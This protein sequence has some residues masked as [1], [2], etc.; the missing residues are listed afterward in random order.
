MDFAQIYDLIRPVLLEKCKDV[1]FMPRDVL[2]VLEERG[3]YGVDRNKR[4]RLLR[5]A[6]KELSEMSEEYEVMGKADNVQEFIERNVDTDNWD[7]VGASGWGEDGNL[8]FAVKLK[9]RVSDVDVRDLADRIKEYITAAPPM[10]NDATSK[11]P[12]KV[13]VQIEMPDLHFNKRFVNEDGGRK[14]DTYFGVFARMIHSA[15]KNVHASYGQDVGKDFT[16]L[17]F[18]DM[19]NSEAL[20]TTEGGTKQD[21][22]TDT[23]KGFAKAVAFLK[24]SIDYIL[25]IKGV[26]EIYIPVVLGNHA[27]QE[28]LRLAEVVKLFYENEPRVIVD[29]NPYPRKYKRFGNSLIAYEHGHRNKPE[30]LFI[31]MSTERPADFAECKYKYCFGGHYHKSDTIILKQEEAAVT[32]TRLRSLTEPD[33]WHAVSGYV[34]IPGCS[35]RIFTEEGNEV[36]IKEIYA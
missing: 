31:N 10:N 19:I 30:R 25:R 28:E 34:G 5:K 32:Y 9:P 17:F 36:D 8:R 26:N 1:D 15:I 33:Y 21:N 4:R 23:Y 16:L 3:I 2:P 22:I 18:N 27:P 35:Y 29:N 24:S 12:S 6:R 14:E 20:G 7:V 13:M 11:S